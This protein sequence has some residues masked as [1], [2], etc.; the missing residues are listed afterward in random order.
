[1]Y[2]LHQAGERTYYIDCPAK[3]GIYVNGG[4]ALSTAGTTRTREK[5]L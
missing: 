5:R 2:E 1:M 3:I 4:S